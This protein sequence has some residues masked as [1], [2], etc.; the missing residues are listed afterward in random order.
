MKLW[1]VTVGRGDSYWVMADD[2]DEA[3]KYVG[4]DV[5]DYDN[6]QDLD[7]DLGY[8]VEG[9]GDLLEKG[10]IARL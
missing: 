6:M 3:L 8:E 2:E 1:K 4:K 9:Y 10:I 5:Y 7:D